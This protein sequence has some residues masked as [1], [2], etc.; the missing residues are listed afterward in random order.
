VLGKTTLTESVA[1]YLFKLMA[2]K[3][4]YEVAR[5]H[6]DTKFHDKLA[7]QYEPG[8]KL[9]YN[10]APPLL[11]KRNDQGELVKRRYGPWMLKAFGVLAKLK[12]VRGGALDVFGYTEERRTERALIGEYRA[13]IERALAQLHAGTHAD[14]VAL[15]RVPDAIRGYGHVKERHLA[16][17]RATWR[18]IEARLASGGAALAQSRAA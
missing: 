17:A 14:A 13:S 5:L 11:A 15:A 18:E 8:F 3:D 1:R 6:T 10:L 2:Y 7:S 9:H 12:G 16:Q 4:E